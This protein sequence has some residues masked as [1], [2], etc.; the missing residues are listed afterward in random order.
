MDHDIP[1]H[2]LASGGVP[3]QVDLAVKGR[4]VLSVAIDDFVEKS[5]GPD[6]SPEQPAIPAPGLAGVAGEV[7]FIE[8]GSKEHKTSFVCRILPVLDKAPRRDHRRFAGSRRTVDNDEAGHG[9]GQPRRNVLQ[10]SSVRGAL[11]KDPAKLAR[12]NL[13]GRQTVEG[14]HSGDKEHEN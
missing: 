12:W 8:D 14:Q 13:G 2:K 11:L 10:E 3:V 5:V 1:A 9:R 6:L 7:G 4:K